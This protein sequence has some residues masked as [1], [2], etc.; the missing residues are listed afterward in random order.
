MAQ[1]VTNLHGYRSDSDIA[2]KT[3]SLPAKKAEVPCKANFCR[4]LG[5]FP[6][7]KDVTHWNVAPCKTAKRRR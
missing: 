6:A 2:G 4:Q 3:S 5:M 1:I 7:A